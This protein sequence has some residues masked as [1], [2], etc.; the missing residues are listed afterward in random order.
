MESKTEE[1]LIYKIA[2]SKIP[3]IGAKLG[4]Q[5]IAYCG[6]VQAIFNQKKRTL[7]KIPGIGPQLARTIDEAQPDELGQTDLQY[8]KKMGNQITFCLDADYPARLKHFEDAPILFYSKGNYDPNPERVVAIVGTRLP[9]NVGQDNC[10][11]LIEDLKPYNVQIISG[12]AYGIDALSH[13]TACRLQI[14]NLA[15]MGTGLDVLYPAAHRSLSR[16]IIN[17]GALISEY[18]INMRAD[19]EN[20]PRR[21]RVIAAMS[22][23]VVV[24]QSA[25]RGGSLIT[26]EYANNYFKDVFAFPGRVTDEASEGCNALIK[27]NKAHLIEGVE[28][29]AYIMRWE[30]DNPSDQN[31]QIQLFA[32]LD[33]EEKSIYDLLANQ[34]EVQLDWIHFHS[35]KSMSNLA[36]T[37]LSLEF[38][39]LV[40]S[41]PGNKYS[42]AHRTRN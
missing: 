40:K 2:L 32:E 21:N 41:L 29:I 6:G 18:P 37:L 30:L 27:Q 15:I 5:L 17:N 34:E 8:H 3:G 39:G 24:V 31:R 12:L 35:K 23:V 14:E 42:I 4:K 11:R 19:K 22:D 1:E 26:A 16:Q 28:D 36:S 9:T 33:D 7:L 38:K 25:R 13:Q 10:V 20:F